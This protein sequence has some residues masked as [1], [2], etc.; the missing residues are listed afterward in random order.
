MS[1]FL[2]GVGREP[3]SN[4][5]LHCLLTES[6]SRKYSEKTLFRHCGEHADRS[7]HC[8][9]MGQEFFLFFFSHFVYQILS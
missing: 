9:H 3:Q 2:E 6:Y 5:D 4:Q 7:L 1:M 8:S